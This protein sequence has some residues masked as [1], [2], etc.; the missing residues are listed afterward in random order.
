[1][2]WYC[3]HAKSKKELSVAQFLEESHGLEVYYPQMQVTKII[4]RVKRKVRVPLF[5]GYL[6]CRFDFAQH[7]RAVRYAHDALG[8]VSYGGQAATLDDAII[9]QIRDQVGDVLVSALFEDRLKVG[10]V[11]RVLDGPM[12]G[13]MGTVLRD[14]CDSDRVHILMSLLNSEVRV[15]ISRSLV[16]LESV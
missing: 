4:R 13:M 2:D 11:V 3:V 6:F 7:Y 16:A 9:E 5:P 1:M 8:L 12:Q 15:N 10:D 14:L